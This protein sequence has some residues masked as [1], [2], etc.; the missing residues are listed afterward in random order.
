MFRGGSFLDPSDTSK[1]MTSFLAVDVDQRVQ[2]SQSSQSYAS[3]ATFR[4]PG[5][6]TG[7]MIPVW[8]N[9]GC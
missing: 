6:Q 1:S 7:R 4:T 2:V 5:Q 9:G 8:Q 3:G